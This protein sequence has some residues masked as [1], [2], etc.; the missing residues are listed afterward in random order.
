MAGAM[1]QK[2]ARDSL[3]DLPGAAENQESV[4]LNF[5]T[6]SSIGLIIGLRVAS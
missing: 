3:A 4:S 6:M 2:A 1:V 5:H